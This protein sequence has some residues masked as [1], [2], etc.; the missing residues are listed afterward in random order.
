MKERSNRFL[1]SNPCCN[2]KNIMSRPQRDEHDRSS[3]LFERA[4]EL[5]PGGVNSPVRAFRGVGGTPRF[6]ASAKGATL[7]DVDG[8]TYIDYVGSWGPMILG[9]ANEEVLDALRE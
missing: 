4:V 8:R 2:E 1:I 9:H 3:G 5:I 7:T 6:I